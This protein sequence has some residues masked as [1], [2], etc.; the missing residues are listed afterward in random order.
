L[1]I[2]EKMHG[3][4]SVRSDLSFHRPVAPRYALT[5]WSL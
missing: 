1:Q 4:V 3:V 2:A 5:F